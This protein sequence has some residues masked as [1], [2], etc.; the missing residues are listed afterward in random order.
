MGL[1]I[2]IVLI[3]K[4][5]LGSLNPFRLFKRDYRASF[6]DLRRQQPRVF[7]FGYVLGM[8]YLL[9]LLALVGHGDCVGLMPLQIASR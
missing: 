4:D 3:V 2:T 8:L 9:V 5:L 1:F 7:R 6:R